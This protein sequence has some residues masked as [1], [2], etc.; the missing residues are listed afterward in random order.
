MN[1]IGLEPKLVFFRILATGMI[2]VLLF[3]V[4]SD[5]VDTHLYPKYLGFALC[6]VFLSAIN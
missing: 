3:G 6:V 5:A 1:F 4:W 2:L